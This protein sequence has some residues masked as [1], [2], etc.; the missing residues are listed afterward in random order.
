MD[1][2]ETVLNGKFAE[3]ICILKY[4]KKGK[5]ACKLNK[6]IYELKQ[7]LCIWNKYSINLY[8]ILVGVYRMMCSYIRNKC[9]TF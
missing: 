1:V 5:K 2:K 8:Y 6:T 7:V 3:E 4:F 9:G